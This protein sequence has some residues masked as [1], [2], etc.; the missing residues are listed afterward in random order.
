MRRYLVIAAAAFLSVLWAVAYGGLFF[1]WAA[2]PLSLP[3]LLL[4]KSGRSLFRALLSGVLLAGLLLG[5]GTLALSRLSALEGEVLPFDGVVVSSG[6]FAPCRV[7]GTLGGRSRV[8]LLSPLSEEEPIPLPGERVVGEVLIIGCAPDRDSLFLPGGHALKGQLL[9]VEKSS[10]P[11]R[12]PLA[13]MVHLREEI[14]FQFGCLADSVDAVLARGMLTGDLSEL[15]ADVRTDFSASGI[16]HILAVSGLHLSILVGIAAFLSDRLLLSRRARVLLSAGCCLFMLMVAGFSVSVL[17]AAMMTALLLLG[18]L[19]GQ[20]SDPLTSLAAAAGMLVLLNPSVLLDLSYQLTCSATLG[21]LLFSKPLGRLLSPKRRFLSFLWN[22]LTVSLAAQLGSLPITMTVF[23]YLPTYSLLLNLLILPLVPAVLIFDLL[24]LLGLGLGLGEVFFGAARG[25]AFLLRHLARFFAHLPF[26]TIPARLPWQSGYVF[27]LLVFLFFLCLA[28]K[29]RLRLLLL[30]VFC[31]A[32]AV[33]FL[34][35]APAANACY[36]TLDHK[37]GAVLVQKGES[38]ALLEA[39][40]SPY[41]ASLL[42]RFL[43]RS[44]SPRLGLLYRPEARHDLTAELR[45]TRLLS[46][47]ETR[48]S[49]ETARLGAEQIPIDTRALPASTPYHDPSGFSVASLGGHRTLISCGEQKVLK[50]W[51]G[52]DIITADDIPPDV[53]LVIDRDGRL[54]KRGFSGPVMKNETETLLRLC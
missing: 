21:I 5:S 35:T 25:F 50:C 12:S 44:G 13:P 1:L 42:P 29:K 4:K 53:T 15:P 7:R 18:E 27:L 22:A 48:F 17:R 38:A 41:E 3:A 45:L 49:S 24:A 39:T 8:L 43:L 20:R 9:T 37:T 52:Y 2:L 11:S 32:S 28:R 46:P 36:L 40:S 31:G 33:F 54:F 19:L 10:S 14:L 51:A 23:G 26:A 34:L 6:G 16:A 47:R 30:S